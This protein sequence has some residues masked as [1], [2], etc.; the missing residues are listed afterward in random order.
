MAGEGE[1]SA[2]LPGGLRRAWGIADPAP[3]R[4]PK[5]SLS[6]DAIVEAAI[7][8][9]NAEGIGGLSITRVASRLGVTPNA[10]YRYI[11]SR[12]ELRLL[13]RERALG[14]PGP[15][16]GSRHWQDRTVAWAH[17]L[18]ARYAEHPWLVDLPIRLP[19]TPNALAWF[20]ALLDALLPGPF[21]LTEKVRIA[22]LLDGY[23][24]ASAVAARDLAAGERPVGESQPGTEVI[25]GLLAERGLLLAA[26][27]FGAGLFQ[28]P[29]DRTNDAD[30]QFGLDRI[31]AGIA[32][33]APKRP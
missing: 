15:D 6:I 25:G 11:G 27:V 4:G 28:E 32:A 7:A 30:F 23:V 12:D 22:V 1:T 16:A 18:R 21:D 17:A 13:A 9:G 19:L 26:E 8:L 20:D 5:A 33:L 24:R 2:R 29:P 14:P 31:I 10:L 3:N